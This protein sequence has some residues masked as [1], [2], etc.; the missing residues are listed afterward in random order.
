M[1]TV[2][3]PWAAASLAPTT[4]APA[5]L[6]LLATGLAQSHHW[7]T[8]RIVA[9]LAERPGVRDRLTGPELTALLADLTDPW[10]TPANPGRRPPESSW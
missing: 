3:A 2:T 8:D 4:P 9:Y 10:L 1:L 6:R 5:Y 7:D